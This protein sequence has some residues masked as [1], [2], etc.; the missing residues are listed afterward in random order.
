MHVARLKTTAKRKT[1]TKKTYT[2][3]LRVFS[4]FPSRSPIA[5]FTRGRKNKKARRFQRSFFTRTARA[6]ACPFLF[7]IFGTRHFPQAA[8]NALRSSLHLS[9]F[10]FLFFSFF[11]ERREGSGQNKNAGAGEGS[12]LY[13]SSLRGRLAW[14]PVAS[15]T[16]LCVSPRSFPQKHGDPRASRSPLAPLG[17]PNKQNGPEKL[18]EKAPISLYTSS[19][20]LPCLAA[21][22]RLTCSRQLPKQK[23]TKRERPR[24]ARANGN[25][26]HK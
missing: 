7:L 26:G 9:S 13:D 2:T 3:F 4:T 15:P 6:P 10:P 21:A 23:P 1:S 22:A 12:A 20:A 8:R 11:P 19:P 17:N 5:C 14:V 16:L 18:A 24:T 25:E